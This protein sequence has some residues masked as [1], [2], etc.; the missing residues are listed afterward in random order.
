MLKLRVK[1]IAE[2]QGF[3]RS[4][5]QIKSGVTLP[6][7]NR[8]WDNETTEVKLAALGKIAKA[9]GVKSGEL[10][11]DVDENDEGVMQHVYTT[12]LTT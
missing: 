6:L 11:E 1:E 10:L 2:S 7:L 12:L 5:L 4:R 3:N 9:L 8:Y